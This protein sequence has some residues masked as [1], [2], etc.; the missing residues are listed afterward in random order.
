MKFNANCTHLTWPKGQPIIL[1]QVVE[2][3]QITLVGDNGNDRSNLIQMNSSH[4]DINT[5]GSYMLT[6]SAQDP[7]HK[8]DMAYMR[9]HVNVINEYQ[10]KHH[11]H[12]IKHASKYI[13]LILLILLFGL[14]GLGIKQHHMYQQ[15][16]IQSSQVAQNTKS[17]N[18]NAKKNQK[19]AKQVAR[20]RGALRQYQKDHDET[21]FNNELADLKTENEEKLNSDEASALNQLISKIQNN[22]TDV[23]QYTEALDNSWW[24]RF[25]SI[26]NR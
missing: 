23:D 24:Q 16:A 15:Q 26:F 19:L 7:Y 14:I 1:R 10:H 12:M 25:M 4:V 3:L 5:I 13:L 8:S 18:Q 2:K 9:I 20:L 11:K 17:I 6:L 22:P 21:A